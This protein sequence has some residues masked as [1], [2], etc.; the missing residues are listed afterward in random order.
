MLRP[1]MPVFGTGNGWGCKGR[2][3]TTTG[4]NANHLRPCPAPKHTWRKPL[5]VNGVHKKPHMYMS[6]EAAASLVIITEL[7]PLDA[8]ILPAEASHL[9]L[10]MSSS[11]TVVSSISE[12]LAA[13]L[14][15]ARHWLVGRLDR[16]AVDNETK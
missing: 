14:P 11:Q 8:V 16:H 7:D 4:T 3:A 5:E 6:R 12:Y 9:R 2:E 13:C 1:P 10:S 15:E